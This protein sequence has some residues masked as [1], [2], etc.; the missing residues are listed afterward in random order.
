LQKNHGDLE[1]LLIDKSYHDPKKYFQVA[2]TM[3]LSKY[4][5]LVKSNEP[6]NLRTFLFDI[7]KK[8]LGLVSDIQYPTIM[9]GFI[10]SYKFV[11]WGRDSVTNLHYDM[12]WSSVFL[13]QFQTRKKIILFSPKESK[14]LYHYPL[15]V[16]SRFDLE[17]PDSDKYPVARHLKSYYYYYPSC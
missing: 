16:M 14:K 13:T 2:K 7:F 9:D 10:R 6:V 3:K 17:N 1:V 5:E 12:D 8:I 11:F 15:T 4:L